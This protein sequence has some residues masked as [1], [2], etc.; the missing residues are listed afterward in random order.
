MSFKIQ[1]SDIQ[2]ALK[3]AIKATASREQ[4]EAIYRSVRIQ[5][6]EYQGKTY[7]VFCTNGGFNSVQSSAYLISNFKEG[8]D[9]LV[10][11]QKLVNIISKATVD[12]IGFEL[13][14][15]ENVVVYANGEN[16]LRYHKGDTIAEFPVYN[17]NEK[18]GEM[19]VETFINL[20]KMAVPF[21]TEDV[22]KAPLVGLCI[23]HN[24]IY[25]T[26]EF[27]SM[28][29]KDVELDFTEKLNF[30]T[31]ALELIREFSS[32]DKVEFYLSR[33]SSSPTN[34]HVAFV[35]D[36]YKLFVLKYLTDFPVGQMDAVNAECLVKGVNSVTFPKSST[37]QAL[38]RLSIF[39]DDN[40]LV[41]F[42]PDKK[43]VVLEVLNA[44]TGEAGKEFLECKVEVDE[45]LIDQRISVSLA[46]FKIVLE[47][48]PLE[49]LKFSFPS[50]DIVF[51]SVNT[52]AYISWIST[53]KTE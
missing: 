4:E 42:F 46:S 37:L 20:C 16:K 29:L 36:N 35:V 9:I 28:T 32:K 8:M 45:S 10:D 17:E 40:D 38:G 50:E 51:L 22:H 26:D 47:T 2:F 52:P 14:D 15:D 53:K 21:T 41:S 48:L 33:L 30:N 11:C 7:A 3:V 23:E 19:D 44:K 1:R 31:I 18:L 49:E 6:G 13:I 25:A 34:S 39:V 24:N 43:G 12:E 5:T 27:R